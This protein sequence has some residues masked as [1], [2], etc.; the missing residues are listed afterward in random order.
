MENKVI[1]SKHYVNG[2]MLQNNVG[3]TVCAIGR[4][5]IMNPNGMELRVQLADGK[6]VKAQLEDQ[7]EE[8]LEGF[9][10]MLARV[11]KDLSLT[12]EHLVSFGA[13]E[14][15]LN[16]YNEAV[17]LMAKHPGLFSSSEVNGQMY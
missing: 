7:L 5:T 13:G 16:I 9:V 1:E 6:E 11:N 15:D 17:V 8:P 4:I 2:A 12:V 3:K 14:I 10:Q